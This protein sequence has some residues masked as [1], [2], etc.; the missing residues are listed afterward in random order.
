MTTT[1]EATRA[2][3]EARR[4][5]QSAVKLG[6]VN[7]NPAQTWNWL[8]NNGVAMRVPTPAA[9]DPL[10]EVPAAA[11]RIACGAGE[12]ATQWLDAAAGARRVVV[13]P[14]G[15]EA[16]PVSV[17]LDA[18][19][20]QVAQTTLWARP[21]S[22]AR[23]DVV[24]AHGVGSSVVEHGDA[25]EH[26]QDNERL[27]RTGGLDAQAGK[28]EVPAT[29]GHALRIHAQA[30]S[31]VFVTLLVALDDPE[32]HIDSLGVVCDENAHVSVRQYVIGAGT[33]TLGTQVELAGE[34]SRLDLSLRYL[35]GAGEHLDLNYLVPVRGRKAR[36]SLDMTGVLTGDARKSLRA[37]IDLAHG[38]KGAKAAEK[39]TVLVAGD[40]VVNKTLPTI[41][42]DEDDV[43]GSHG[44]AIGSVSP[45]QLAY[46]ADR[47]LTEQ[48]AKDLFCRAIVDDAANTLPGVAAK[49]VVSWAGRALGRLA[50]EEIA[51]ALEIGHDDN[52]EEVQR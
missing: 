28:S 5:G 23:V 34:R 6:D 35:A 20:G 17:V 1:L 51:D 19:T 49:A 46:L 9:A 43:E 50:A 27:A 39:E 30:G 14:E 25:R 36:A 47:G 52:D 21:G 37:T 13:V 2:L 48:E 33:T 41:L 45:D 26:A 32:Q 29:S 16:E 38:C 18:A 3:D 42:C 15:T 40:D 24:V 4:H 10:A 22:V 44:A 12:G 7:S 11:R 8:K 31:Q